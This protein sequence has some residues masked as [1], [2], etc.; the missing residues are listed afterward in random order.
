M[1][2]TSEKDP[3]RA[4]LQQMEQQAELGGGADRIAKQHEAGKLT[5]RERIDL[6]L[7]PGS[8]CELDKFVT[9]RSTD[10]GMGDKKI[11][12]DGVVTGY[13]TVEG[14]QV[15][16]FAQDFTVFG[17]SLSG[18]Y[19]QKICKIMDMATRV[20]APVIGLNDSG[21]ARIQEGV[22]SLAGYA[23]IFLR[24][25]LAS[26]V[27]PQISLIMGPCA[28][29][30]VYSP[31]I[32]DFIMMVKDTSYMFITGPDVIKT[33]THEEVSKESLGGALTHNQKS[34]V[35]HFAAET[36]QAAIVMTRELLSFLPSN[37][38]EDPP[39]Q[40]CDDDPFRAEESLKTIVPS[41]PNKP[42]D[43]KD[44]IKAVVDNK[45]FFEVQEHFARNIVVGFARMNGKSVGIVANQPAFLAGV[46]DI[47]ASVKAARFVRFCDCF[48]IPLITFVDVPGFLPGT[49]QEWG[50]IITHGAKLLYAFAEATVPKITI[51][52]RKAYGGAYD[53]MASKHIRAD[54]NYAYP[55]AEIAV[56]GPEGAVNII[57]R[58]ELLKAKDAA[59][60]RTKLV[61]DYREKF[62]NPFK[63][64][65]LGY[66]DEVI[67]PE[68]TRTKVIRALEMLK[69]KRQ[70]NPPRK[71]GN[72][73]L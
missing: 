59:A 5:A 12:G 14:R 7:D 39:A 16:V 65:E 30:A 60:E 18:A 37:N 15:F 42:Y 8:F 64:A 4:R 52:T 41:N 13:G 72:I 47:D 73:P 24:N 57:F 17:G 45:H 19:A 53:V 22:E 33:V 62:A 71:H 25:T 28:G 68:E 43:I 63:A 61:N 50:G 1:D 20:G 34:G 40:P 11:P 70:E 38:Q 23:D 35:A 3:L 69:D 55:T 21:G 54:I 66:I 9:H 46:L 67:R 36:E 27:V 10:F 58:N 51:I 6:L 26:G 32:T 29:G 48:N 49:D 31:A 2:E 56:M 44:I